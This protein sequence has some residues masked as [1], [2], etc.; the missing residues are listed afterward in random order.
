MLAVVFNTHPGPPGQQRMG[1]QHFIGLRGW[2]PGVSVTFRS[3]RR[4]GSCGVLF[5]VWVHGCWVP[6]SEM[7]AI[8]FSPAW[9]AWAMAVITN[10]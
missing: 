1:L 10:A 6:G 7:K 9:C 4:A 3:I 2:R 5:E 8:F